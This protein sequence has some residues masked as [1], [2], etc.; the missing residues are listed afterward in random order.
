MQH[1]Q[2]SNDYINFHTNLNVIDTDKYL[3]DIEGG[4]KTRLKVAAVTGWIW[5]IAK[6]NFDSKS[7]AGFFQRR[8][9]G[10]T[11]SAMDIEIEK[12]SMLNTS[13]KEDKKSQLRDEDKTSLRGNVTVL[14]ISSKKILECYEIVLK[15]Y[16]TANKE[17]NRSE[18]PKLVRKVEQYRKEVQKLQELHDE[19]NAPP[20]PYFGPGAQPAAK[21]TPTPAPAPAPVAQPSARPAPVA[22]P[23]AQPM[24]LTGSE[25]EIQLRK[26]LGLHK[27]YLDEN[28][29]VTHVG[30]DTYSLGAVGEFPAQTFYSDRKIYQYKGI[31]DRDPIN[32]RQARIE[33]KNEAARKVQKE[34]KQISG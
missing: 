26:N 27:D 9:I 32:Q 16:Q 28:V 18:I 2:E 14:L 10:Y 12:L 19:L 3:K 11:L 33:D 15:T 1:I 5:G 29:N 13:F 4:K 20:K 6:V 21:P 8:S 23:S 31:S 24:P 25:A 17:K 34:K 7:G 22:Q 30:S